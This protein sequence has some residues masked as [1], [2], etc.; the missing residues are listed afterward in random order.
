M[1]SAGLDDRV[2]QDRRR[3]LDGVDLGH[4]RGVDQPRLLEQPLV[5]PRRELLRS[6]G[7][8]WRCARGRTAPCSRLRPTHAFSV[9]PVISSPVTGS[10]GRALFA[11]RTKCSLPLFA[12]RSPRR[13][14]LGAV[15]GVV[16]AVDLRAVPAAGD[17]QACRETPAG[18]H[19]LLHRRCSP[20]SA[21]PSAMPLTPFQSSPRWTVSRVD[22][23]GLVRRPR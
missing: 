3:P 2:R 19:G 21:A 9:K 14:V 10:T 11:L 22:P 20:S 7:R 1:R 8:R 15:S 12:P 5:V 18:R 4:Q 13:Q 23:E 6:A 17:H 16:V